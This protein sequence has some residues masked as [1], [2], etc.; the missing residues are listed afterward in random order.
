[1]LHL[2]KKYLPIVFRYCLPF[3]LALVFGDDSLITPAQAD[4]G[5]D[6][7]S[8]EKAPKRWKGKGKVIIIDD[9]DSGSESKPEM[10]PPKRWKGKG[11]AIV[12]D[13]T[14]TSTY[15]KRLDEYSFENNLIKKEQEAFD[16]ELAKRLQDEEYE[17]A[18]H[19]VENANN[20]ETSSDYTVLSSEIHSDDSEVTKEKKLKVKEVEKT[21]KRKFSEELGESS[22]SNKK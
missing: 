1:M 21:L 2:V 15:E 20:S 16:F 9:T 12:M 7:E 19:T 22:R 8:E 10:D 5:E 18:S 3:I 14:D 4:S 17:L 6:T 11:R 13:D